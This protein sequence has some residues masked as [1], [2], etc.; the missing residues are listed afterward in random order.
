MTVVMV[1]QRNGT[2]MQIPIERQEVLSRTPNTSIRSIPSGVTR[3]WRTLPSQFSRLF[4]NEDIPAVLDTPI[5]RARWLTLS[6]TELLKAV[7]EPTNRLL[8]AYV[9]AH[10]KTL[11]SSKCPID[12]DP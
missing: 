5:A 12:I 4:P 3:F 9:A 10:A 6:Q 2:T 11:R 7:H 8:E 1:G